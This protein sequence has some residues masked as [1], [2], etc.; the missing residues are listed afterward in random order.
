MTDLRN[1][2]KTIDQAVS[3]ELLDLEW[4]RLAI[5]ASN[6]LVDQ[7]DFHFGAVS[8]VSSKDVDLLL[9]QDERQHAVLEAI[10]WV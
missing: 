6:D 3:A 9:R 8:G 7:V 5:L 4:Y 1:I 2:V 10:L